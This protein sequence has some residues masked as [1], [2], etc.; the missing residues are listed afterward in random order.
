MPRVEV[1]R[2]G[3]GGRRSACLHRKGVDPAGKTLPRQQKPEGA[4]GVAA[5]F[6][7]HHLEP[8]RSAGFRRGHKGDLLHRGIA[9]HQRGG[10]CGPRSRIDRIEHKKGDVARGIGQT[11]AQMHRI[12]F[13]SI[14][15][16]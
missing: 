3:D 9:P 8:P 2:D 12:A 1:G 10:Q 15:L 13:L 4:A 16:Q 11:D 5:E 7:A 6:P 14:P